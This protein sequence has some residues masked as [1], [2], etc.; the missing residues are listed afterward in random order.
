L[1][2]DAERRPVNASSRRRHPTIRQRR[3]VQERDR[4]CVDC[5]STELLECDHDPPY[6]QTRRT[7]VEELELRCANCHHRRHRPRGQRG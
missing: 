5:G 6:E 1:I 7:I 3:V 4:R 2:H